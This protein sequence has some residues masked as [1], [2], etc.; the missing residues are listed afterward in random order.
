[1]RE[2]AKTPET[3][4]PGLNLARPRYIPRTLSPLSPAWTHQQL[5]HQDS[6]LCSKSA[7]ILLFREVAK[8]FWEYWDDFWEKQKKKILS[9]GMYIG[10]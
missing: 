6:N 4:L 1:M 2:L 7:T 9:F 8:Y 5:G 3:Y 10:C